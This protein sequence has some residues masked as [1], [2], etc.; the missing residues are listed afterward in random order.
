[1]DTEALAPTRSRC[2]TTSVNWT[3]REDERL[4]QLLNLSGEAPRWSAIVRHFPG[5]TTQQL[6]GRWNN[7]L[8]PALVKGSWTKEE[9]HLICSFVEENGAGSWQKLASLLPGRIGKQCRER[10]INHLSPVVQR[11]PWSEQEDNLLAEFHARFGNQWTKIASLLPGR[12]DNC[13]KNRWNSTL[14]RKLERLA[15]G[16]PVNRKRGRKPK[17][18]TQVTNSDPEMAV[19]EIRLEL[20]RISSVFELTLSATAKIQKRVD[21]FDYE[22]CPMDVRFLLN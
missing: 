11:Q 16:E 13:V 9:D 19:S 6:A 1:M 15:K 8:N 17:S 18:A 22:K 2:Q 12:T 10:W 4:T 21:E 20:P 3:L 14:K 5:K 7:V